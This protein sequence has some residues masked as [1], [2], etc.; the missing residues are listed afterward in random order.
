MNLIV[1]CYQ[2]HLST[3]LKNRNVNIDCTFWTIKINNNISM[4]ILIIP[5]GLPL[6]MREIPHK[7]W[8]TLACRL[9]EYLKWIH[10]D[11]KIKSII[12]KLSPRRNFTNRVSV[13]RCC[14]F[15]LSLCLA[16]NLSM[17]TRRHRRVTSST[18]K[19]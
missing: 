4:S 6:I 11:Y 1:K 17:T 7:H 8:F 2:R 15:S 14:V 9:Y 19:L 18:R 16:L 13:Q 3:I 5:A 10:K 12:L